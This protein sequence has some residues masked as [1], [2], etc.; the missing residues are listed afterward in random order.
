MKPTVRPRVR[1]SARVRVRVRVGS[2]TE[3]K[4]AVEAADVDVLV[5]LFRREGA[6]VLEEVD[7]ACPDAAV[8]VQDQV[9]LLLQRH[10]SD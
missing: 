1:V 10:L 8:D 4:E 6:A 2:A 5:G 3:D 7:E 9:L